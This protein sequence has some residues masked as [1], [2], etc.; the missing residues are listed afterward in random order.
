MRH[1]IGVVMLTIGLLTVVRDGEAGEAGGTTSE[2]TTTCSVVEVTEN[3][4]P[5]D[6]KTIQVRLLEP[7]T[8]EEE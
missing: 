3:G 8:L 4:T 7:E 1:P 2:R 6:E 5:G